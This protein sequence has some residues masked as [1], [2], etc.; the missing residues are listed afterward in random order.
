MDLVN[1]KDL[2]LANVRDNAR[3]VEL[4][5]QHRP[6]GEV[7]RHAHLHRNDVGK[8]RLAESGGPM[9]KT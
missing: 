8:R 7:E 4:F 2:R 1:E 3:E 6:A 5:L 9:S